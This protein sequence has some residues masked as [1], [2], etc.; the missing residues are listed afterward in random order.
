VPVV[1]KTAEAI[2]ARANTFRTLAEIQLQ[3]DDVM[4][5]NVVFRPESALVLAEAYFALSEA[6]KR[7]RL[8]STS[9]TEWSK[10]G[11]LVAATVSVISPLRPG[12]RIDDPTW[13]Y[14]NPAFGML[15]AYGHTQH[16][17]FARPFDERRRFYQSL[18][19]LRLP[20]LD[21]IIAEANKQNGN[22]TSTWELTLSDAEMSML[23]VLVSSFVLLR[24]ND[25]L[26]S[27]KE[28]LK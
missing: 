17:F 22:L 5:L 4:K 6:Y 24:E 21:Y 27:K 18:Q 1:G 20:C 25:E 14:L 19:S 10:A 26:L 7:K 13:L 3:Q 23:D 16:V 11:A 2:A 9:L 12:G 8:S 15:C 28:S